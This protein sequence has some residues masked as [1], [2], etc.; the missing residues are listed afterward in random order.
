MT[1]PTLPRPCPVAL[2]FLLFCKCGLRVLSDTPPRLLLFAGLVCVC[3]VYSRC[4]ACWCV[5]MCVSVSLLI[6]SVYLSG[7]LF[8]FFYMTL[9]FVFVPGLSVDLSVCSTVYLLVVL[10]LIYVSEFFSYNY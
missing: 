2:P 4:L 9:L 6:V 5:P 3:G 7:H 1:P 8:F 10:L